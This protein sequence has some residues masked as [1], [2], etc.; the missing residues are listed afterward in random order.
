MFPVGLSSVLFFLQTH[1]DKYK[2]QEIWYLANNVN[3]KILKKEKTYNITSDSGLEIEI[4]TENKL[5]ER[6][7]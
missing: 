7:K 5:K 2:F 3:K 4:V 6:D 1:T